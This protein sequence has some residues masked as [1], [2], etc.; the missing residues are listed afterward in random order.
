MTIREAVVLT[1][2]VRR[3]T[4]RVGVRDPQVVIADE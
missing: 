4:R 3:S 2:G 1:E